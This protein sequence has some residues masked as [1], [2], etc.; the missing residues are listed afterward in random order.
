MAK[1]LSD[2]AAFCKR[3]EM[4]ETKLGLLALNDKAFVGQL[5]SGRRLWP[6]TEDKV[7]KFMTGYQKPAPDAGDPVQ[8]AAAA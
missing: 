6:E 8:T 5:R 7:R 2:I 1:L 3:H 4:A